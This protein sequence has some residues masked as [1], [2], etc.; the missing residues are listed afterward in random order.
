MARTIGLPLTLSAHPG[1]TPVGLIAGG[2]LAAG[3]LAV[4][5]LSLDDLGFSIC[6][7]KL[8]TGL[9][10]PSCGSTRALGCLAHFDLAGAFAMNPLAT[11]TAAGIA[12]WAF[13][14]LVMVPSRRSLALRI[15]PSRH[16]LVLRCLLAALAVNWAYLF[17]AGR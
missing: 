12:L 16:P 2:I 13:L 1:A 11:L 3:C 10:C 8:W 7:F 9:P 6:S 14:D 17:A 4:R 5:L 15:E